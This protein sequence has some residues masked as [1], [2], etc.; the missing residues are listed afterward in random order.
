MVSSIINNPVNDPVIVTPAL[1]E[2]ANTVLRWARDYICQPHPELGRE[3]A[4]CPFVA[5][6]IKRNTFYM[7]FYYEV[8]GSRLDEILHL[9]SRY[10]EL[11]LSYPPCEEPN[12]LYKALLLVFPGMSGGQSAMLDQAQRQT[13][14]TYVQHG[15]MLGQFHER[16]PEPA[17]H[18]PSFRI[19][20]APIP[21][22]AIRHMSVHDV[23]FLNSKRSWFEAYHSRFGLRYD[24]GRVTDPTYVKA[25]REAT[26]RFGSPVALNNAA[27]QES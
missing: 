10:V 15:L 24:Q 14:D 13:K 1:A 8:D 26:E 17:V 16:C 6:S 9:L 18:N 7:A 21:L 11:F 25:Y 20:I 4:I 12:R 2:H 19:S 3:G 27:I 23:I 22:I 5:P